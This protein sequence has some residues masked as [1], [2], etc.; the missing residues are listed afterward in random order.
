[1]AAAVKG[2]RVAA[3]EIAGHQHLERTFLP[4]RRR[5]H[6]FDGALLN[7]VKIFGRI[8][9]AKNEVVFSIPG[10]RKLHK[11]ALTILMAQDVEQGNVVK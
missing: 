2:C 3:E 11:N 10:F 5:L 7:N 6:A 1:M 4:V 9:F 8:P